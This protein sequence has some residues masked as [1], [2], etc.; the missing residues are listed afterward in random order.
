MQYKQAAQNYRTL[1]GA[2]QQ[3]L[4]HALLLVTYKKNP[5]LFLRGD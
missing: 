5:L 2:T 3:Q 1:N 4:L